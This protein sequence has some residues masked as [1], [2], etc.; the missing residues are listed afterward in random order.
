[1][2]LITLMILSNFILCASAFAHG[3]DK[4]GP[5]NGFVRMPG[6]FHTEV[7]PEKSGSYLVYLLD[8]SNKNPTV[9]NSSVEFK[10]KEDNK[11]T[12]F[13]CSV[14]SQT[15]YKCTTNKK[16]TG[17]GQI[18]LTAKRLGSKGKPTIYDM[19]LKLTAEKEAVK[20]NHEM[21]DMHHMH[22]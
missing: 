20:D 10:I 22:K 1:M 16:L 5:N 18:I 9:K 7:V 3:E 17:E 4:Y 21:H 6:A 15:H 19:P 2:K 13:N 11:I 12:K 14:V 8:V